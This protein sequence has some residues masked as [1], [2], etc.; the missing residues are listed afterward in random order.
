MENN[1]ELTFLIVGKLMLIVASISGWCLYALFFFLYEIGMGRIPGPKYLLVAIY[2]I[3]SLFV[4]GVGY[5]FALYGN[6]FYQKGL[7]I[8]SV[9][10][11]K[12]LK[13][14]KDRKFFLYLRPFKSTGK[15]Y[16][17]T[18][19]NM[20]FPLSFIKVPFTKNIS[21]FEYNLRQALL[22]YGT[23]L[24]FGVPGEHIGV[25]R[26]ESTEDKWRTEI[27]NLISKAEIIFCVP[28]SQD[29]IF[30]EIQQ[31]IRSENI[32]RKTIFFVPPSTS[33][34]FYTDFEILIKKLKDINIS[35]PDIPH[36]P[37]G[38]TLKCK[39]S[40]FCFTENSFELKY[41]NKY[42]FRNCAAL[43]SRRIYRSLE[44]IKFI[45]VFLWAAVI[46]GLLNLG[47]L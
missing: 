38:F 4:G 3:S 35:F 6:K 23:V 28:S 42:E 46:I 8:Q 19:K 30:W 43:V 20:P 36:K 10:L 26:V 31:I 18:V 32:L 1:R 7:D 11:V 5:F 44:V 27:Q 41:A 22:R 21:D 13:S 34:R 40:G 37:T 24:G 45:K 2:L 15:L 9:K 33:A 39:S 14:G 25:G 17:D 16:S 12:Q 29:G 47:V